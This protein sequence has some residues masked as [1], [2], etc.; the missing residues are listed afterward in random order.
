MKVSSA[1]S[2]WVPEPTAQISMGSYIQG[3]WTLSDKN[4]LLILLIQ[5]WWIYDSL[6]SNW[7]QDKHNLF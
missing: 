7:P 5:S 6:D 3:V 2:Q 1:Q 4:N